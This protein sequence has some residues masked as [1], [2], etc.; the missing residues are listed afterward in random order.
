MEEHV[1]DPARSGHLPRVIIRNHALQQR[2]D[3]DSRD[4]HDALQDRRLERV[5]LR[6][7]VGR[8]GLSACV[9]Q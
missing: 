2:L 6:D 4:E 5:G 1:G 7:L 3:R 8:G 9:E